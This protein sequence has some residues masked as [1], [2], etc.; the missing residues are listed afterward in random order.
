MQAIAKDEKKRHKDRGTKKEAFS[1]TET[2]KQSHRGEK[3]RQKRYALGERTM[4]SE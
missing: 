1:T 4:D 3:N 2:M